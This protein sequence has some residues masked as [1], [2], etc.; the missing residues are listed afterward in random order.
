MKKLFCLILSAVFLFVLSSCSLNKDSIK[1]VSVTDIHFAGNEYYKYKGLYKET[2]ENNGSGK[3]MQYLDDIT[4]A[5]IAEMLLEKPDFI[6]VSGDNTFNGSKE[7][8]LAFA[9]KFS[10]LTEAGIPYIPLPE[11]TI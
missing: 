11:T 4:D 8:H 2:N 6:I 10:A 1:I 3:Q 7:S 5:F 9:D